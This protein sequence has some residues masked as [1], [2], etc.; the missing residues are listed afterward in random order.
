MD[1]DTALLRAF[2]TVA[3]ERH[4]GRAAGRL[5]ISQQ[6]LSKRIAR[7]ENLLGIRVLDR[8]TRRIE[9]T[10]AGLRLL[11]PARAAVEAV[12]AAAAAAGGTG[13]PLRV[14]VMEE[15]TAATSLLRRAVRR[16]PALRVQVTS[17]G[18]WGTALDVLRDAG[19]DVAFGRAYEVPWPDTV[20]RRCVL[21]EPV[22]LLIGA[23]HPW[24]SHDTATV[25]QLRGT[26][27]R[28]PMHSAPADWSTFIEEFVRT[29]GLRIDLTGSSIGF[30]HFL[31]AA[32][33]SPGAA[34]FFGRHMPAP[35]D[36]RLRVLPI[37]EPVPV[38]AWAAMWRRP[39]LHSMVDR[40]AGP[41]PV[42]MPDDAWLPAVDRAWLDL[43]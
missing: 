6:A 31:S 16:E 1:L 27:L 14:D 42:G 10:P 8:T 32:A 36:R 19:V 22:G 29:F 35:A 11:G 2:V 12:D 26:V 21:A 3:E 17:R 40:L 38:F 41:D 7:L 25:A 39:G 30:E 5:F 18:H 15:H 4:F 28:F 9:P 34:T 43:G 24:W 20:H 37:V 33:E 13:D 23:G